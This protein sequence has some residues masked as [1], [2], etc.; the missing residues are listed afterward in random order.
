MNKY[1][2]K[3]VTV[4]GIV[5]DSKTEA[6]RYC[7]LRMMESAGLITDLQRQVCFQ[8]IPKQD[9]ERSCQYIADFVYRD[10]G[11]KTVVEDVKGYRTDTYKIKR[12]LMLWVH[13]IHIH[14]V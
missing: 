11:G 3:K 12:K 1:H 7:Q 2:A 10:K 14:E 4:D 5:F 6:H 9:G 13:G 8:L